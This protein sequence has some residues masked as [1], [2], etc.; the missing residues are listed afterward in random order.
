MVVRISLLRLRVCAA[1]SGVRMVGYLELARKAVENCRA[2]L[3]VAC[4]VVWVAA[5]FGYTSGVSYEGRERVRQC[6]ECE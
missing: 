1:M 4:N 5:W 3:R 2:P 6:R